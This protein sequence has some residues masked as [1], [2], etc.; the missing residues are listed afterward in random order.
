ML[1]PGDEGYD[2]YVQEDTNQ[3]GVLFD[4]FRNYLFH[5]P[6]VD[7]FAYVL[8]G[9]F[10]AEFDMREANAYPPPGHGYPRLD[11]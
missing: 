3:L 5:H 9:S 11:G 4:T 6:V 10:Q 7:E 1:F 8:G 2:P